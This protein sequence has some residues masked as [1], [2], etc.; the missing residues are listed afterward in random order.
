[1]S[2]ARRSIIDWQAASRASLEKEEEK[3]SMPVRPY[4]D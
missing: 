3:K 2:S 1:M 4:K